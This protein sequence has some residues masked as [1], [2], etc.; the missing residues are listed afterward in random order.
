MIDIESQVQVRIV[1]AIYIHET[2]HAHQPPT[3]LPWRD[4]SA[5]EPSSWPC[6]IPVPTPLDPVTYSQQGHDG[7]GWTPGSSSSRSTTRPQRAGSENV[8]LAEVGRTRR[9]DGAKE[10]E[11]KKV[12]E[13][14]GVEGHQYPPHDMH[15]SLQ[16]HTSKWCCTLRDHNGTHARLVTQHHPCALCAVRIENPAGYRPA[17]PG[18]QPPRAPSSTLEVCLYGPPSVELS[19]YRGLSTH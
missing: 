17:S 1:K 18:P 5:A 4:P 9:E 2:I 8:C 6:T 3:A 16:V 11:E 14:R 10:R 13:R 12:R 15:V 19:W 7:A